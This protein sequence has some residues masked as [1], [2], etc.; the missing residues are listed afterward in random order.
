M[1]VLVVSHCQVAR[2][3]L[4]AMLR[5]IPE[6]SD[7]AEAQD[8]YEALRILAG[9]PST[10]RPVVLLNLQVGD[11]GDAALLGGTS[12]ILVAVSLEAC[13][14]D[15]VSWAMAK[16]AKGCFATEELNQ[17]I[18]RAAIQLCDAGG[19]SFGSS[20]ASSLT[21][22]TRHGGGFW[23]ISPRGNAN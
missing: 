12:A 15:L 17:P 5:T 14:A 2:V 16:G 18:L 23:S 9:A 7:V 1:K 19:L 13:N 11:A 20:V 3:G 4:A 8:G 22:S 21:L 10:P 6:V